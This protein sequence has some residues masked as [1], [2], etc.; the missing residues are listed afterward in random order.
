MTISSTTPELSVVVPVFNEEEN[1]PELQNRLQTVL[2][3]LFE[4]WEIIYVDDGSSDASVELIRQ[5]HQDEPQVKLIRLSRNFG[6]QA[7]LN[8]GLDFAEGDGVVMMDADLQDP[9]EL[10]RDLTSEWRNGGEVVYAIRSHREGSAMKRVA[11]RGFY[12]LYHRLASIDVPLDSGDFCLVDRQVADAIR[13]LPESQRFL[14]GLRSWVGFHQVGVPYD[15]PER[16][17][18]E[19][20]YGFRGLVKL[21]MDGLLGFSATPLRMSSLLGFVTALAGVLYILF[22]VGSRVRTGN[23]PEGWTSTVALILVLGGVQLLVIGIVGEY[24]ARVFEETKR[25]PSYVIRDRIT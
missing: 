3:E 17:A 18:G 25:R 4:R 1:L 20:K 15:R 11:Y 8:A 6:H 2:D 9:P 14:R 19:P 13:T 7:A 16:F 21:A 10:L 24:L 5:F 12:R 22:A 23:I